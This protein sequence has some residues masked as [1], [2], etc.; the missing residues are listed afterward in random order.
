MIKKYF[1]IA[2]AAGTLCLLVSRGP[3]A[4]D[5]TSPGGSNT[6]SEPKWSSAEPAAGIQS[7]G[8]NATLT[9]TDS[10]RQANEFYKEGKF[11]MSRDIYENLAK[12]HPR[13]WQLA[14]NLGNA[15]FKLRKIGKAIA[16]YERA[17]RLNPHSKEV[18]QN[19]EYVK[20][21]LE[22]KIEDKR[23]WYWVA[24]LKLVGRVSWTEVLAVCLLL[25]LAWIS[26]MLFALTPQGRFRGVKFRK[27]VFVLFLLSAL[28]VLTKYWEHKFCTGAVV[29]AAETELRYGPSE[30]DKVALKLVEGLGVDVRKMRGDWC[31]VSLASG[32]SGWCEKESIEV[33]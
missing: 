9:R 15:N 23:N 26:A 22:Y 32:E 33:V 10:F 28:P 3:L 8:R 16:C 5:E 2:F 11:E 14:Y 24:W 17:K 4:A 31:L 12:E 19:L 21:L 29:I 18:R 1:S 25:Y 6:D 20:G 7:P 27:T 30:S 13:A